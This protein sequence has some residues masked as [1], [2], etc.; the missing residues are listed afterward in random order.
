[1]RMSEQG[2]PTMTLRRI[3]RDG[4]PAALAIAALAAVACPGWVGPA[5]AATYY[6]DGSNPQCSNSGSGTLNAPY[7]TISAALAANHD[8]GTEI[9][10]MPGTYREQVTVAAS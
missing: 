9:D 6:V 8:P 4:A 10:V 1:M 7:C 5:D 2:R 3:P